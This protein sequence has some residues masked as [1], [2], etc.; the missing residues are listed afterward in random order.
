MR[1]MNNALKIAYFGLNIS[2]KLNKM[3]IRAFMVFF[4][5]MSRLKCLLTKLLLAGGREK[6]KGKGLLFFQYRRVCKSR[7]DKKETLI[8]MRRQINLSC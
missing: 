2:I 8:K 3:L 4:S 7:A 1:V 6:E 5:L